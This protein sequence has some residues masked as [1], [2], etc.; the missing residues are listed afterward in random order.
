MSLRKLPPVEYVKDPVEYAKILVNS[1]KNC[2]YFVD[3][4]LGFDVFDYNKA[5]LDCYDRFVVYRTGRQV[6]KST[7][8]AL[9]AIHFAFFAPLF[10]SNIDTGV[11]NVVIAS[12]SKDQAHLILSKISE[13]IHMSPTLSKKVTRE[14]KTEITIEWY[15]GTGKTNFIVRPIGDT[16]D[17]LRGFTVHYAILD[18]AAYI[19]QVVFDAFLPS[20]VTT[21]PHILLTS[22][23]KGKSGQF[24]KSCMDSH[25]LYE[26]GKPKAIEGH[27]DKQK[28]PWTQ[29]H[30]TTFDNPLA[31]SD[32]QVLKL[33][34]GTTKAAE[35]QEIYG[36]FLDGGNSL[37][38]YNLLQEALTPVERPKFE[39]YDAGVDTS[40]KGADE[41]V[42]T[43]AGIRDGVMYPVEIYTELTT[44]Q[45]KL[46]RKISEY[47]RIYGLRRIYVDETGMGDTLMDLCREVD[48]DMNLYGINFKSDK[49]NLYINLERL[50]EEINPNGSGRLINLSLLD[51][52][53]KDKITEQLSY[54]YWDHG[55]F[56]D[57]QPKVRS[58]H[59]DDY[60]DSLALVSFGQQ[61]VDFI[62]DVPDL[63]SPESTG[64]YI[65]W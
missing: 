65:G 42:I 8:A 19:P 2:S 46:A 33:I 21:K 37:I 31:A 34:R 25:T 13:F 30:V 9:K 1:F 52:Y 10:A 48:P 35:R 43:I 28:Y 56:K 26:H 12:L 23:P 49:T 7:N 39:Y 54:M 58:E 38:P 47:N 59:A 36:E 5:F 27:Q 57:Q 15:D 24:F 32:P 60:S 53:N 16:G 41:T 63:W 61:K 50:F 51:D 18:E 55:K 14:I 6:G 4:F 64:E 17:S 40:G 62:R 44:E 3:K 45:P 29:F 11:A 22:T 20:T